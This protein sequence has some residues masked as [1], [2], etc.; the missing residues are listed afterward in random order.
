MLA[1]CQASVAGERGRASRHTD[2][3]DV[4]GLLCFRPAKSGGLSS[5]VSSTTVCNEVVRR[6]PDL[7]ELM[8]EP[9]LYDR[10]EEQAPGEDPW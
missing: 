8:Y 5:I 2:G 4:V 6:R 7:V 3:S 1:L 9:F 10:R